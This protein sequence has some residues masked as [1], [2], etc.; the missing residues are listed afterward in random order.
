MISNIKKKT[1]KPLTRCRVL[2]LPGKQ[3]WTERLIF[4]YKASFKKKF[5]LDM[6][7]LASICSFER[8]QT[9]LVYQETKILS[10]F[11]ITISWC[12]YK[13]LNT[14]WFDCNIHSHSAIIH[15]FIPCYPFYFLPVKLKF[16]MILTAFLT[17]QTYVRTKMKCSRH[18]YVEYISLSGQLSV[19]II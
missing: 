11:I 18:S 16:D 9:N 4:P 3:N 7:I 10:W 1:K 13:N 19:I 12:T 14:K 6:F 2:N 8:C 5:R 15:A 17:E